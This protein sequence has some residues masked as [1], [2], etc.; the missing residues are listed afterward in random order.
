MT[1]VTYLR[2]PFQIVDLYNFSVDGHTR[3]TLFTSS[4]GVISPPIPA[5]S[6]LSVQ[7]NGVNL[8]VENVGPI[9]G[10]GPMTGSYIIVK[11]PDGLP[12]GNLSLTITVNGVTSAATNLQIAQ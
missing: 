2:G 3:L 12:K 10:M 8:P 11:L 7:A 4:L 1:A 5:T 6:T 9:T